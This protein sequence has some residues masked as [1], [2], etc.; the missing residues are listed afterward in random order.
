M[1]NNTRAHYASRREDWATPR[2]LFD[3]VNAIFDFE[4]DLA[5]N[6]DNTKCE[7]W[8]GETDGADGKGLMTEDLVNLLVS[9]H[10]GPETDWAWCNPPYG[11]QGCGKVMESVMRVP[12]VVSLIPAPVGSKWFLNQVWLKADLIVFI[13]ERLQF[14]GAP[15]KAMFDS[16]LAVKG[17]V[18][19]TQE[20]RLGDIGTVVNLK[21]C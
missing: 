11:P 4:I 9:K 10:V 7:K 14:E 8:I 21:K 3:K 20:Y 18:N 19:Y 6:A 13:H 16:V 2:D 12:N 5:A 1:S 17:C 15:G